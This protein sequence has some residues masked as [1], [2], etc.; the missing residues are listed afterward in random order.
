MC[1]YFKRTTRKR[2]HFILKPVFHEALGSSPKT[3]EEPK[4]KTL[5]SKYIDGIMVYHQRGIKISQSK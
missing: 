4:L 5:F 3:C 2:G 1:K